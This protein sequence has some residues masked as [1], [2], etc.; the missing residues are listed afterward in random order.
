MGHPTTI[1]EEEE[2]KI[3]PFEWNEEHVPEVLVSV[4]QDWKHFYLRSSNDMT[5]LNVHGKKI[6]LMVKVDFRHY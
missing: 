5:G 4:Y 3:E 2:E 1:P 6:V